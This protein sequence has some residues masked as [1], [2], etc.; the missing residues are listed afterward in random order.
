MLEHGF[1]DFIV[2]RKELKDKLTN[3]LTMVYVKDT[4]N[5]KAKT[6]KTTKAS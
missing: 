1:L 5:V 3:L 4:E 6:G 2:D